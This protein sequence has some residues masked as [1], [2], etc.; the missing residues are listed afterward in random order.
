MKTK[1][2]FCFLLFP[3]QSLKKLHI[4]PLLR[5]N[6]LSLGVFCVH[7][8]PHQVPPL[9]LH[10]VRQGPR[11]LAL[12]RSGCPL[13]RP[14]RQQV[15]LPALIGFHQDSEMVNVQTIDDILLRSRGKGVRSSS[16]LARIV[17]V[18]DNRVVSNPAYNLSFPLIVIVA[19]QFPEAVWNLVSV[20][21]GA[22]DTLLVAGSGENVASPFLE[23]RE[24]GLLHSVPRLL[25]R[26]G[27]L[28]CNIYAVE[29]PVVRVSGECERVGGR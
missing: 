9:L 6:I 5:P 27:I 19:Y 20:Q 4:Q 24:D 12:G 10:M 2:I 26:E 13:L 28:W 25:V 21:C 1:T 11:C 23:V 15:N 8:V 29:S 22:K 14:V 18:R 16:S 7:R 17:A 3:P